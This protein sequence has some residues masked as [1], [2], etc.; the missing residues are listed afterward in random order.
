MCMCIEFLIQVLEQKNAHICLLLGWY[1]KFALLSLEGLRAAAAIGE[2]SRA[3]T[4]RGNRTIRGKQTE[5]L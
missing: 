3:N 4:I 2:S 5:G 1:I